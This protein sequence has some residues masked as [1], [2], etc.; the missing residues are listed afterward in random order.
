MKCEVL[1]KFYDRQDPEKTIYKKGDTF[2][3]KGMKVTKERLKEL[4]STKNRIGKKLIKEVKDEKAKP[5][6]TNKGNKS[7]ATNTSAVSE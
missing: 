4:S 5:R 7:R 6:K 2:P 3:R 1:R